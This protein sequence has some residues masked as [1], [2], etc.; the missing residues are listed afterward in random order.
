LS[1]FIEDTQEVIC[2]YCA[3][4]K[5]KKNPKYEIKEIKE[6]SGE[7]IKEVDKHLED[8]QHFVETLRLTLN[9]IQNNKQAEVERVNTFYEEIQKFLEEK[10]LQTFQKIEN[11]FNTNTENFSKQ[12]NYFS[13]RMEDA[14]NIKGKLV[15]VMND[16]FSKIP[17]ALEN[18][19]EFV[20][21]SNDTRK[22]NMELFEFKFSH[23]D[24][25]KLYKYLSNF[26]DLK[27]VKKNIRFTPKN[28]INYIQ[29]KLTNM[30][31]NINPL[32]SSS[33]IG[34]NELNYDY[35]FKKVDKLSLNSA[36]V[37][38]NLNINASQSLKNYD[39]ANH[40]HTPSANYN[41]FSS[42]YQNDILNTS[43]LLNENDFLERSG[44]GIVG[45]AQKGNYSYISKTD[46]NPQNDSNLIGTHTSKIKRIIK[47]RKL[48]KFK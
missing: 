18:Y 1:H 8:N 37:N 6:K 24:E 15:E 20:K 4:S 2:V 19:G 3:F 7:I 33:S 28:A 32:S 39:A 9:D 46:L 47:I 10:K 38:A 11:M 29:Q 22:F 25:S 16:N 36:G 13:S 44:P 23:D 21:E 30:N 26:G 41:K 34:N 5:F 12:L 35:K 14:E 31:M 42:Q 17:Q 48:F 40:H 43:D 45:K 27:T